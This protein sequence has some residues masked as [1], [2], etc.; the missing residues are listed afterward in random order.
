MNSN[1]NDISADMAVTTSLDT[2]VILNDNSEQELRVETRNIIEDTPMQPVDSHTSEQ[3][4]QQ[5][6]SPKSS[7]GKGTLASVF[8]I[9]GPNWQL[10][11]YV[12]PAMSFQSWKSL[13][14]G[15]LQAFGLDHV[16]ETTPS[17]EITAEEDR[18]V[19]TIIMQSLHMELNEVTLELI[20]LLSS[21]RNQSGREAFILIHKQMERP[22][23]VNQ[24]I[25]LKEF[26]NMKYNGNFRKHLAK[27]RAMQS[28]IRN[29]NNG[30]SISE[31]QFW[32]TALN[33]LPEE[34]DS[35]VNS[36]AGETDFNKIMHIILDRELKIKSKPAKE[37][38]KIN[39]AAIRKPNLKKKEHKTPYNKTVMVNGPKGKKEL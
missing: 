8:K 20:N 29:A 21:Q 33:S 5:V 17:M 26:F 2:E 25:L 14:V 12:A 30:L 39:L 22:S 36:L 11:R 31:A 9:N 23:T 28:E 35:T 6:M 37:K 15:Y 1:I 4:S 19:H 13:L 27:M 7:K 34:Y 24:N 10:P 18:L 32:A 38:E 3:T 16:V